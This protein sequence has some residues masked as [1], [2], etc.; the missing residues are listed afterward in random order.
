MSLTRRDFLT[1]SST[2]AARGGLVCDHGTGRKLRQA[3]QPL[4]RTARVLRLS[5]YHRRLH[6]GCRVYS[7]VVRMGAVPHSL[8]RLT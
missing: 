6:I 2:L 4:K 3:D 7:A 8:E 1:A 5:D